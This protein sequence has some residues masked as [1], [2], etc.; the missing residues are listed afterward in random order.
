MAYTFYELYFLAWNIYVCLFH[1][2]VWHILDL[3]FFSVNKH[4]RYMTTETFCSYWASIK[5]SQRGRGLK[6]IFFQRS[7]EL[8][9]TYFLKNP[10]E[11]LDLL[12]YPSEILDKRKLHSW[13]LRKVVLHPMPH[14]FYH[15]WIFY[16][17][18]LFLLSLIVNIEQVMGCNGESH[19]T[20]TK[21]FGVRLSHRQHF[22]YW[23][24]FAST[25]FGKKPI[26]FLQTL[27]H[28]HL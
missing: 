8:L 21:Y 22:I 10:R 5:K 1:K 23:Q 6:D 12:L 13:K 19:V 28:H 15:S 4:K 11:F 27:V 3:I 7:L 16:I 2:L 25:L 26:R 20:L 9:G 18:M 14:V 17:Y 24:V